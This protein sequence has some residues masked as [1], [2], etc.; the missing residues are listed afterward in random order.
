MNVLFF[1]IM[2]RVDVSSLFICLYIYNEWAGLYKYLFR[3]TRKFLAEPFRRGT[4]VISIGNHA[5]A[6]T[7][8][9]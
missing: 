9:D 8:W 4:F 2:Q 7:I 1:T 6:S 5:L 3:R